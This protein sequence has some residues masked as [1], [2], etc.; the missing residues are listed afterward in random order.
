[1]YEGRFQ[2]R[3]WS[4]HV[5]VACVA[6]ILGAAQGGIARILLLIL[7]AAYVAVTSICLLC[8]MVIF[9]LYGAAAAGCWTMRLAH[10]PGL[11]RQVLFKRRLSRIRPGNTSQVVR[12]LLGSP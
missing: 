4:L 11:A 1:M 2:Y 12:K 7:S 9:L 6:L 5:V 3:L 8:V 10:V